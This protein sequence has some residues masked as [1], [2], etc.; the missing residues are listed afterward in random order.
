[1]TDKNNKDPWSGRQKDTPPD[2][3]ELISKLFKKKGGPNNNGANNSMP[4]DNDG[5][6]LGILTLLGIIIIAVIWFVAGFFIISPTDQAPVL[7]FGKY[8]ETVGPGLHWIPRIADAAFPVN[9]TTINKMNVSANMLTQ[10]E[11][12]VSVEIAVQYR[13]DNAKNFLFN[14]VNPIGSLGQITSSAMRQV[15]GD[16]TLDDILTTGRQKVRTNIEKVIKSTLAQYH[17]GI[18][19]TDVNLQPAKP[20]TAVTAAFDDAINAREDKQKYINKA[21]A[22]Q[23]KVLSMV[24]GQQARLLQDAQAYKTQVIEE[25][26]GNTSRYLALLKPYDQAPQVISNKLYFDTLSKIFSHTTNV[27]NNTNGRSMVYLPLNNH[28][29][30]VD[31]KP[32]SIQA[33]P[34]LIS[35]TDAQNINTSSNNASTSALLDPYDNNQRPSYSAGD[36]S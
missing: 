15:I 5:K 26:K 25:A 1:M 11:N 24:E 16:T 18:E 6:L 36:Q 28:S 4:S 14:V 3:I 8:T 35:Q 17:S 12:I 19:I 34:N 13:I 22:Y 31:A 23:N 27:I 2:L 30:K 10:D 21:Q 7:R 29:N 33:M 20:P 32:A 9:T